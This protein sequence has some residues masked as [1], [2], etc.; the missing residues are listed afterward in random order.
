TAMS[1]SSPRGRART[2]PSR[3]PSTAGAARAARARRTTK[4]LREPRGS[5]ELR[6]SATLLLR[7]D[8]EVDDRELARQVVHV[9]RQLRDRFAVAEGGQAFGMGVDE[10][11]L[12]LA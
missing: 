8:P 10:G 5:G 7:L 4:A 1:V 6:S 3:K 2:R 11:L 12:C 9:P